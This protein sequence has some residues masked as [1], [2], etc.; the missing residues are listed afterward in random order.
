[1]GA[2]GAGAPSRPPADAPSAAAAAPAA[3]ASPAASPGAGAREGGAG[4]DEVDWKQRPP[5]QAEGMRCV[6][7]FRCD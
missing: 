1:V 5:Q 6:S 7:C 4:D 3:A 2:A